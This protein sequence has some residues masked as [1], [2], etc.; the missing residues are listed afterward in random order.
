LYYLW[1]S[2]VVEPIAFIILYIPIDTVLPIMDL[3]NI[4]NGGKGG[5]DSIVHK[6]SIQSSHSHTNTLTN[7]HNILTLFTN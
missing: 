5:K 1:I 2:I 3:T 4:F 6:N 7:T